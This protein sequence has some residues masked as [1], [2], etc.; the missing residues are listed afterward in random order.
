MR[1]PSNLLRS[2]PFQKLN[3]KINVPEPPFLSS[4]S[5]ISLL[6]LIE[7]QF[8]RVVMSTGLRARPP[9]LKAWLHFLLCLS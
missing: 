3:I 9:G 7:G 2:L 1:I 5:Q 6:P 4:Y 8:N